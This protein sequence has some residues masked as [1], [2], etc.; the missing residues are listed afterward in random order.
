MV[1]NVAKFIAAAGA[2]INNIS[3][4]QQPLSDD[5]SIWASPSFIHWLLS[6]NG[7]GQ[8]EDTQGDK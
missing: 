7:G 6:P 5:V 8:I 1:A 3:H 2:A 4:T